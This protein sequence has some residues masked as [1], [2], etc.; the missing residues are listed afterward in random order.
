[1][2]ETRP[3]PVFNL[4]LPQNF[5]SE[6]YQ[7]ILHIFSLFFTVVFVVFA[8]DAMARLTVSFNFWVFSFWLFLQGIVGVAAVTAGPGVLQNKRTKSLN[9]GHFLR[10]ESEFFPNFGYTF[11][12]FTFYV[13]KNAPFLRLINQNVYLLEITISR[14]RNHFWLENFGALTV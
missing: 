7:I 9:L 6:G 4:K 1:M 2:S 8:A 13:G 11:K 14:L 10:L 3:L 5:Y 12:K